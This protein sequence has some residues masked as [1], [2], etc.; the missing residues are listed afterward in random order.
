MSTTYTAEQVYD[1]LV[2]QGY[3]EE[4]A[5]VMALAVS[6]QGRVSREELRKGLRS[7]EIKGAQLPSGEDGKLESNFAP[8]LAE[9]LGYAAGG[10]AAD[11]YLPSKGRSSYNPRGLPRGLA[12]S[13]TGLLPG[14]L[15]GMGATALT[16]TNYYDRASTPQLLADFGGSL[17]GAALGDRLGAAGGAK[18]Q[19][20]LNKGAAN[21]M[22][23]EATKKLGGKVTGKAAGGLLGRVGG[24]AAGRALGGVLGAAG[25]PAG[26]IALSTLLGYALPKLMPGGS[27]S[28]LEEDEDRDKYRSPF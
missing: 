20:A 6:R 23:A 7:L 28:V 19:A 16:G 2:R 22:A 14:A 26:S 9:G 15:A 24:A 12:R 25:G 13:A 4:R 8:N 21:R 1:S 27:K 5:R 3:D 10:A 18:A 11:K 17:A